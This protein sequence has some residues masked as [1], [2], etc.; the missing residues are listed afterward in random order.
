M[1]KWGDWPR[2]LKDREIQLLLPTAA[3]DR[4]SI[5]WLRDMPSMRV[6]L[7]FSHYYHP[8]R[9]ITISSHQHTVYF[10]NSKMLLML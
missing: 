1:E 2:F 7:V 4:L 8:A 6:K 10:C 9:R 5:I 3:Y